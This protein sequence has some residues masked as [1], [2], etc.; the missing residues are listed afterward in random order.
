MLRLWLF[1]PFS[2]LLSNARETAMAPRT[3]QVAR[4]LHAV[5]LRTKR[6][7]GAMNLEVQA[8]DSADL[9]SVKCFALACTVESC[10][11]M[12]YQLSRSARRGLC[13]RVINDRFEVHSIRPTRTQ[14]QSQCP[15]GAMPSKT[16]FP[17]D[18]RVNQKDI[19]DR[20]RVPG[21]G[22]EIQGWE[23]KS[24]VRK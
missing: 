22:G 4:G 9:Y 17:R 5:H 7:A 6:S 15:F 1:H 14:K 24:R 13:G 10:Q 2:S 8:T 3:T 18:Q 16:Q 20:G 11:L 19:S 21:L 12:A 23:V